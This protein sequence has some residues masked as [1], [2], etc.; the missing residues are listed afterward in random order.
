LTL[1]KM[2]LYVAEMRM[3]ADAT[4]GDRE[5]R[6]DE[7]IEM[8]ELAGREE[9]L[10][11]DLSG[12]QRK[13]ASIAVELVS[14]PTV[15]FLDEPS[16][17]LDPGTERNLMN[18]L[19][20]MTKKNK[21]I[22]VITHMTLNIGICDK[23]IILGRGGKLCFFG[24]PDQALKYF[25]VTDFVDIYEII[26]N[27]APEWQSYFNSVRD[28]RL[29]QAGSAS[30]ATA[31][32]TS[33]AAE[34]NKNSAL[35]QFGVLTRRYVSLILSDKKRL[36]VLLLQAPLLGL[37][38]VL[39]AYKTD[40]A[41]NVTTYT[42]SSE[43]KAL[44]FSLSCAAFW[45]GMLNSVQEICKERDIFNRERLAKLKLGPYIASKL[46][47]LGGL[48]FVQC[49]MLVL[50]TGM[51]TG[52]PASVDIGVSPVIGMYV[53]TFLTAFSAAAMG[54]AVSAAS[55]NPDRAMTL[56]PIV[57]MPQ[58]LFSGIAFQLEDMAAFFANI[59]NCKWSV[60][61]YCVLAN[62]NGIP[63][64][65]DDTG[66]TFEHVAYTVSSSNLFGSWGVLLLISA[67]CVMF[68]VFILS[69]ANEQ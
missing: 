22:V 6:V 30:S 11:R 41:G 53:T 33:G 5:K 69:Y 25:N 66:T 56:A 61:A 43:A 37:L 52:M 45:I 65:A 55:P 1:K 20:N 10:I 13:R 63:S 19:K 9:T 8:V 34:K 50:V 44:L 23:L 17:G 28:D 40:S 16:S 47:V 4:L 2:L 49:L 15:F 60:R 54:L 24:T 32:L 42:Y 26:N 51:L 67:V 14:D 38:L 46:A 27:Y 59:I 57:L 18:M 68:S 48:C 21:T 39:V 31:D 29:A 3:P 12:G 7:V 64:N 62:I 35:H 58:I 36:L